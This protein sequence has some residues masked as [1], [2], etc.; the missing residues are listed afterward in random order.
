MKIR[1]FHSAVLLIILLGGSTMFFLTA[2]NTALQTMVGIVTAVSYIIWG[3]IHHALEGELHPK[4]V[5]EYILIG[6]I[7]IMLILTILQ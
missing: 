7:A 5:I 4:I 6:S 1:Y 3:I 2:G